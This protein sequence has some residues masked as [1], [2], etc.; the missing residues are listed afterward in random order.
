MGVFVTFRDIF[1][2]VVG[3]CFLLLA[4]VKNFIGGYSTPKPF[5]ISQ[6][7]RCVD[8][9]LRVVDRW[10]CYLERYLRTDTKATLAGKSILELGPGSDLGTGLYLLWQGAAEYTA[11]DANDLATTAPDDFYDALFSRIQNDS[12]IARV[13]QLRQELARATTGEASRLRFVARDDFDLARACEKNR[14]DLVFSQ[15]SF[16]HFDDVKA[17]IAGLTAV[18]RPGA[19]LVAQIDLSTHSRWIRDKDPNN[20]YRYSPAIYKLFCFRGIPNRIRPFEYVEALARYGWTDISV[21]P[22]RQ[23]GDEDHSLLASSFRDT[24]NQME[25][26]SIILCARKPQ[27]F[28]LGNDIDAAEGSV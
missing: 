25:L 24:E 17:T 4:K 16:E 11:F 21:L 1:Y 27:A 28:G 22:V 5:D 12:N 23:L 8:Y 6:V 15:A 13:E 9:D 19:V 7:E 20:I 10:L 3:L 2:Y 14:V 18:C 26:L